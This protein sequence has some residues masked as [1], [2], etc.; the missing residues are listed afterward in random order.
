MSYIET[1][2]KAEFSVSYLTT[3][4]YKR[5][6]AYRYR[7]EV[8]VSAERSTDDNGV[9]IEFSNL[10]NLI[11]NRL[12]DHRYIYCKADKEASLIADTLSGIGISSVGYDFVISAENLVKYFAAS[13]QQA[14]YDVYPGV[15][16]EDVKL[17]ENPN[18]YTR[19]HRSV[20]D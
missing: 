15:V 14:L 3:T 19:W 10:R 11:Q 18:S 6:D 1:T 7:I 8:T 9:V 13:I 5:F 12:P 4:P 16:V 2:Q 17:L 20:E